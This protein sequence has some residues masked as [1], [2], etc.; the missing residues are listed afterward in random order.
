MRRFATV[1][2]LFLACATFA[3]AA[4]PKKVTVLGVWGGQEAEVFDAIC[5]AFTAKTGI[6]VDFEATRDLDAVITTR[7]EAGNPPD[8]C[9]LTG[10]GKMIELANKGKLADLSKVLDMDTFNKN[11]SQ[12]WKDLGTVN[13]RLYGIYTKAAVKGLVWYNPKALKA[14]GLEE[15]KNGW[16]WDDMLAAS[17]RIKATGKTPWAVGV[18]SGAAS[19]WAGTDWIENIFLRLYGPQK[20]TDW[21]DGKVS[22]TSPEMKKAWEYFGQIVASP[23][24]AFG[25]KQYINATN[26]GSA[27]APLFA[28][29]P[30]AYFHQ[31]ASFIQ[32]FITEQFPSAKPVSDFNFV[33]F[34]SIDAKY[35]KSMEVAA[36]LFVAF[37]NTPEIKAFMD[38]VASAEAQAFWAAGTG[39]LGTNKTVALTFYPDALTKRAA[40]ILNDTTIVVFDA[41]DM[42]K[43]EMNSAFCAAIVS[44]INKPSD[45]DKILADLEKV[46]IDAY[47]KK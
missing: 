37:K 35:A 38:Y 18:E 11:Y 27:V 12:G 33:G 10:P 44:Y 24:M 14:A 4:T 41:S 36:D 21:Y 25:G 34:P 42:M 6:Q 9:V 46:R 31:Q 3:M 20:Y 15:P 30:Q 13:G 7:V 39:G 32:S 17:A 1:L 23:D 47:G 45:L 29:P 19:G 43:S 28:D 8:V 40:S 22:W 5:K 16:T 2:C 26:F